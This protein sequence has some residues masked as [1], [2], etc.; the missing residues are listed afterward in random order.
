M[1]CG[2]PVVASDIG[3]VKEILAESRCGLV[4]DERDPASICE[5]IETIATTPGLRDEMA[6]SAVRAAHDRYTWEVGEPVFMA[7]YA[8]LAAPAAA[9]PAAG[10]PPPEALAP[11]PSGADART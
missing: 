2:V 3:E 8:R 10:V 7:H 9:A 4:V 1:A 11:S 5:A 6:R